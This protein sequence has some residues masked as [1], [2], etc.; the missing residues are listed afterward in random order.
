MEIHWTYNM[1]ETDILRLAI[2][3]GMAQGESMRTAKRV[4]MVWSLIVQGGSWLF[5]V[6]FGLY[7]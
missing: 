6:F 7:L 4:Q 3:A 1:T 2:D 5:L